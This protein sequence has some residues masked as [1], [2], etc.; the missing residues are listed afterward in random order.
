[1]QIKKIPDTSDLAKKSD[2]NA[3]ITEIENKIPSITDLATKSALAAIENKLPDV[4]S[5]VKKTDYDEKIS[6]I[7]KKITDHHHDKYITTPEFNNLGARV[8]NARLAQADLVTK[9]DFDTKLQD[10][11]KRIPSNKT[12]YLLVETELK[13]LE[14][15]DEAYFRGKNYFDDDG[16]QNYLVFEPVYR[17]F[18]AVSFEIA[19]W[20]SKRLFNEKISSVVNSKGAVPRIVY[21]NDRIK[22]KFNGNLLKQDKVTCNHRPIVNICIIYRLTPDTKDSSVT[23]QNFLFGA[24]KL[25]KNADIVKYKYS[26]YGIGFD[27]RG[28]FTHPSGGYRRNV[29]IFG[30]DMSNSAH[31]KKYI[32]IIGKRPTQGLDNTTLTAEK[33]LFVV[34]MTFVKACVRYFFEIFIFSPNDRSFRSRDIQIFVIFL[35]H[36]TLSKFKRPNGNGIIYDVMNWLA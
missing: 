27:S 14:R 34:A 20:K 28:S 16:T 19:S 9:T 11:N 35:F 36:S 1:M 22:V 12:K 10:I 2:L 21:D 13:K 15:F 6:G 24:V 23:L 4:S 31:N 8:F 33:I 32:L 17:Y 18:D 7:E 29:I 25:T 26:G 5:L 3:K 30:A